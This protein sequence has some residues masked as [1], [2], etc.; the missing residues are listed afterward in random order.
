MKP[1]TE[2]TDVDVRDRDEFINRLFNDAIS[3]FSIFSV[4]IGSQLGFYQS[5]ANNGGLTPAE[6]AAHTDTNERYVREWLEHQATCCILEADESDGIRRFRLA[7]GRAEVLAEKDSL[8]YL[9]PLSQLIVG[10]VYP[11]EE[12]IKAYKNGNGV[13]F[14]AYGINL[15]EGQASMNRP[16]FLK[17]LGEV[18]LPAIPDIH[19]RLQARPP[20]LIADIGCG[21]GWSCIGM[22]RSYPNL[23]VHGYDLDEASVELARSNIKAAGLSDRVQVFLKDAS[24]VALHGRYNLVTAFE[25]VHDMSNPVGALTTMRNLAGK[26]GAVMIVDERA[27]EA[28]QACGEALE[29]LLYGFSILHC[30]PAGMA[31]QPSAA[32][33]T[34]MRPDTLQSYAMQAGF[35][36]MEILPIENYFFRFYRLWP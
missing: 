10:S 12:V 9:A 29:Q 33:G 31:D 35:S 3:A 36:R 16:A 21:G 32:T 14:S 26:N 18:W 25:C 22:A 11:L 19:A 28:F 1:E 23:Q 17:E 34:V 6:L 13:P 24:D 7:P 15:R 4:Y 27:L 5:L 8:N 30:L 20:A 2:L